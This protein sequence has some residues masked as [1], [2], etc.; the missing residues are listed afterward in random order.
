M[1]DPLMEMTPLACDH[2]PFRANVPV[3]F[4]SLLGGLHKLVYHDGDV[5]KMMN[6]VL[7][8]CEVIELPDTD[9]IARGVVDE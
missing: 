8:H 7:I 3:G 6:E 2:C 5:Q 1:S 9:A 4:A